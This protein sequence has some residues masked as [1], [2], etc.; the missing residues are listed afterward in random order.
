[1]IYYYKYKGIHQEIMAFIIALL[2]VLFKI[3]A[4][5]FFCYAFY[6]SKGW[7]KKTIVF[8][9]FFFYCSIFV[10]IIIMRLGDSFGNTNRH[11]SDSGFISEV[12]SN[13][14]KIQGFFENTGKLTM[15]GLNTIFPDGLLPIIF[16]I[17]LFGSIVTFS[18]S[19]F[20]LNF[21]Y[22]MLFGLLWAVFLKPKKEATFKV[23]TINNV[24][25]HQKKDLSSVNKDV[26]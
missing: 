15:G 14:N 11:K 20:I 9:L 21:V 3:A 16:F 8:I 13:L 26:L 25:E 17:I 12:E 24:D 6:T 5:F 18:F 7:L 4:L 2:I 1:M 22:F 10:P 23:A 19:H